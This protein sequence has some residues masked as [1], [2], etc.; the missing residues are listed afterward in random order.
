MYTMTYIT[1]Y[2]THTE[3][4]AS[5][6]GSLS[7]RFLHSVS[8]H[9]TIRFKIRMMTKKKIVF[10]KAIILLFTFWFPIRAIS[11]IGMLPHIFRPVSGLCL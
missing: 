10:S 1:V 9:F 3:R 8:L 11:G 7:K 6:Y 2:M 4:A 5:L